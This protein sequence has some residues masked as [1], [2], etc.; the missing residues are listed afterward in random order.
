MNASFSPAAAREFEAYLD[1]HAPTREPIRR[2]RIRVPR[3]TPDER[4]LIERA[5]KG[6]LRGEKLA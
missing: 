6:G 1:G 5:L 4:A 3:P 2:R